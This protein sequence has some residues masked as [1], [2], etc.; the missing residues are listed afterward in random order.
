MSHKSVVLQFAFLLFLNLGCHN[1]NEP[2]V[3][4]SQVGLGWGFA[5]DSTIV[6]LDDKTYYNAGASTDTMDN[7]AWLSGPTS[8]TDGT[9]RCRVRIASENVV[10]DQLINFRD[11]ETVLANYNRITRSIEIEIVNGIIER[12]N[13]RRL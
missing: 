5:A 13:F 1:D 12:E 2:G 6:I 4:S 7:L 8:M 3:I 10:F 11:Q 9:H